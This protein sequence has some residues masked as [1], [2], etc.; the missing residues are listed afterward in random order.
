MISN[1]NL[2]Q[3]QFDF[4]EHYRVVNDI[5]PDFMASL[6]GITG[7]VYLKTIIGL[8]VNGVLVRTPPDAVSK[9]KIANW[10][11]DNKKTV[12]KEVTDR[13]TFCIV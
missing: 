13:V 11:R 7:I 12:L 4:I 2:N 6:I 10:F 5:T 1:Q 8:P 3:F 9:R